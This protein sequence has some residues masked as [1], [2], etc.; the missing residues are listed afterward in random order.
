MD[1][2][3]VEAIDNYYNMKSKYE[4]K[5]KEEYDKL[6]KKMKSDNKTNK[7]MSKEVNKKKYICVN[8]KRKVNSIFHIKD[9]KLVALCGDTQTPCNLNIEIVKGD[10]GTYRNLQK[11]TLD[12][13]NQHKERIFKIKL[14][15]IFK[16]NDETSN[17]ALF[18]NIKKDLNSEYDYLL[19]INGIFGDLESIY[20][21]NEIDGKIKNYHEFIQAIDI[22]KINYRKEN[23]IKYLKGAVD[24]YIKNIIPLVDELY[25]LKYDV[26]RV[27]KVDNNE[28]QKIYKYNQRKYS[29]YQTEIN[30]GN[31]AK[32]TSNVY[33]N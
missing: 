30:W 26:N 16:L 25:E 8:C 21:N 7:Q 1:Q 28:K 9:N 3:I 29:Y 11:D 6:V 10:V 24:I 19:I 18:E 14:D 33:K 20:D 15:L 2:E 12:T 23:D 4:I 13:I 31:E 27:D 32:I 5:K 22:M 17:F